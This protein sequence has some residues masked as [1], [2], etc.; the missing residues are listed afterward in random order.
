MPEQF[1]HGA[2]VRARLEQ[3]GG[4]AVPQRVTTDGLRDIGLARRIPYG[5]LQGRLVQVVSPCI[6]RGRIDA[7]T[8]GRE[9]VL[10]GPLAG[11]ARVFP[12]EGGPEGRP[13]IA[14]FQVPSM[15]LSDFD[16]MGGEP[17]PPPFGKDRH[18]VF[19]SFP[20]PDRDLTAIQV[21]VLHPQPQR[22][23]EPQ[24]AAVQQRRRETIWS[25]D[26][27]QQ[28]SDLLPAQHDR[29]FPGAL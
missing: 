11:S 17:F 18:P 14:E 28:P 6:P 7:K 12:F 20:V 15:D 29:Q 23:H 16:K 3:V 22:L 9:D 10:P 26:G 19:L 2:D 13:G 24:A 5:P 8:R 27:I 1:L 4:E 21:D 25:L